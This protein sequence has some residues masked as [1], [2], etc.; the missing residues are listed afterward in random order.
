MAKHELNPLVCPECNEPCQVTTVDNGI[1][2]YEYWGASGYDSHP[3]PAS[4]CCEAQIDEADP[5]IGKQ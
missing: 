1:G 5:W 2:A 3:Y 4:N